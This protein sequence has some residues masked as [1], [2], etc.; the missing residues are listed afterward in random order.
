MFVSTKKVVLFS[1]SCLISV[2]H[3][4]ISQVMVKLFRLKTSIYT[5]SFVMM[6]N[7]STL[8]T[9]VTA[10]SVTIPDVFRCSKQLVVMMMFRRF[11]I[12]TMHIAS[13]TNS[14]NLNVFGSK[15]VLYSNLRILRKVGKESRKA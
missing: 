5:D 7:V 13:V 10:I 3:V 12:F 11:R 8:K 9:Q 4:W 14:K 6:F 1:Q 15:S 2:L